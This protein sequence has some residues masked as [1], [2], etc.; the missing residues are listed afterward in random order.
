MHN[1]C[2][3]FNNI[4]G[5]V[6]AWSHLSFRWAAEKKVEEMAAVIEKQAFQIEAPKR[7]Y[8]AK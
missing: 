1:R 5:S 2:V 3:D 8:K 6:N 4:L 7:L